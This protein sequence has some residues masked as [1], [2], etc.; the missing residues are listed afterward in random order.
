MS[1]WCQIAGTRDGQPQCDTD[2]GGQKPKPDSNSG[3]GRVNNL[4]RLQGDPIFF[5]APLD[6][7]QTQTLQTSS[8]NTHT[9]LLNL[10][11]SSNLLFY[12]PPPHPQPSAPFPV[13]STSFLPWCAA[14]GPSCLGACFLQPPQATFQT[15]AHSTNL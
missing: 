8:P 4:D 12:N 13:S 7:V 11:T 3:A 6:L 10:S 1:R 14:G 9:H 15:P 2:C 5:V